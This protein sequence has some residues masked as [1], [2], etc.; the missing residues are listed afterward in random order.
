MQVQ[1]DFPQLLLVK[2]LMVALVDDEEMYGECGKT[3]CYQTCRLRRLG[4]YMATMEAAT[5]H[6]INMALEVKEQEAHSQ[7]GNPH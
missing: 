3:V 4:Y 5:Q 6:I 7:N 1:A 2:E